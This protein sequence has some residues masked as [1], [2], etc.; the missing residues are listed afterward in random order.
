MS[1]READEIGSRLS[2]F[3]AEPLQRRKGRQEEV[4]AAT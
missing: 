2:G 4:L 1:I 3:L